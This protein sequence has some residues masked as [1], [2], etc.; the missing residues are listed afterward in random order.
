MLSEFVSSEGYPLSCVWM[1]DPL[2][3]YF[4]SDIIMQ[5]MDKISYKHIRGVLTKVS[6]G[7]TGA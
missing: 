5:N 7:R 3:N 4:I 2:F 1:D 6:C